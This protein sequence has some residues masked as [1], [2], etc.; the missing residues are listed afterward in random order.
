MWSL[1]QQQ[2]HHLGNLL[3]ANLQAS[4]KILR[5]GPSNFYFNKLS[6]QFSYLLSLRP[7]G[8]DFSISVHPEEDHCGWGCA[9]MDH[10]LRRQ[11]DIGGEELLGTR[12][13]WGARKVIRSRNVE[14]R[15]AKAWPAPTNAHKTGRVSTEIRTRI[16]ICWLNIHRCCLYWVREIRM[17]THPSSILSFNSKFIYL[18]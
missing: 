12:R 4:T 18:N 7:S 14:D 13:H 16:Q 1:D 8:L 6:R 15:S 17:P 3:N 10:L 2:Q 9:L 5:V 11:T